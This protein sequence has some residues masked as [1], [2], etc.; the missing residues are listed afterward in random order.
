MNETAPDIGIVPKNIKRRTLLVGT[1][2]GFGNLLLNACLPK[3]VRDL[4]TTPT[5]SLTTPVPPGPEIKSL[6]EGLNLT[7]PEERKLLYDKFSAWLDSSEAVCVPS[8]PGLRQA[9]EFFL[10]MPSDQQRSYFRVQLIYRFLSVSSD[11]PYI[12]KV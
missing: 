5:R 1:A 11:Y 7:N 10:T 6:L 4:L 3:P 8:K 2:L 12:Y 9:E